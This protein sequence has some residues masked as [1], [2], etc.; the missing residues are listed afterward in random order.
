MIR[1]WQVLVAAGVVV[2][3]IVGIVGLSTS[4][5]VPLRL[6]RLVFVERTP[7]P[8]WIQRLALVDDALTRADLRRAIYEWR[9]AYEE[10]LGSQRWDALA[11][12]GDRAARISRRLGRSSL[13]RAE[14]REVYLH[15]LSRARTVRSL[16]GVERIAKAFERLGDVENARQARRIAANLS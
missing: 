14:A 12:V 10:A 2:A 3:G 6:D 16:E 13:F 9:G 15:A 11:E 8:A 5:G 7:E 4:G 1:S